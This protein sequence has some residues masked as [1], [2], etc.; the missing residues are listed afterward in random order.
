MVRESIIE[1]DAHVECARLGEAR[2][3]DAVDAH[4]GV[5]S[6]VACDS[7][8]ILTREDYARLLEANRFEPFVGEVVGEG[9]VFETQIGAVLNPSV[10]DAVVA[11]GVGPHS[12]WHGVVGADMLS[13][14]ERV[15]L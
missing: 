7:G 13:I 10:A 2:V 9:D 1:G 6:L 3:V 11:V 5:K 14:T 4:F 12:A 15:R 8:H